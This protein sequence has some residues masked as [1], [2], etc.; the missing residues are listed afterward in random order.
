[1]A[2]D[3]RK[4]RARARQLTEDL[5]DFRRSVR[6]YRDELG[7]IADAI[8][9]IER[10]LEVERDYAFVGVDMVDSFLADVGQKSMKHTAAQWAGAQLAWLQRTLN[11]PS[12][13]ASNDRRWTPTR[14]ARLV[15]ASSSDFVEPP[16]PKLV[17]AY[18]GNEAGLADLIEKRIHKAERKIGA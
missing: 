13:R 4:R 14:L 8:A 17:K 10:R 6:S 2:G 1:M 18:A 15:L 16:C 3:L 7:A 11:H 5:K 9:T 12:L